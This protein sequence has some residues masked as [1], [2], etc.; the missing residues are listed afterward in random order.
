MNKGQIPLGLVQCTPQGTI[1]KKAKV[2]AQ[3]QGERLVPETVD[4]GN[5]PYGQW[6]KPKDTRLDAHQGETK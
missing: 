1:E 5:R 4:D 3:A 2:E 6:A